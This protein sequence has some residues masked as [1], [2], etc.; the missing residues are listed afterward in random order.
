M[1][2]SRLLQTLRKLSPKDLRALR[3]AARNP[4]WNPRPE[5]AALAGYV[6]DLLLHPRPPVRAFVKTRVWDAVFPGKTYSEKELRYFMSWLLDVV[7]RYLAAAELER[8]PAMEKI[9]LCRALRARGLDELFEK[10]QKEALRLLDNDPQRDARNHYQRYLLRQENIEQHAR[11]R[12]TEGID[13]QPLADDLTAFYAAEILRHAC[14]SRMQETVARRSYQFSLLPAVLDAAEQGVF[15]ESPVVEIFFAAYRTQDGEEK[16]FLALKRLLDDFWQQLSSDDMRGLYLL[17]INFC[18]RKMNAGEAAYIREALDLYRS[19]LERNLLTENGH[20]TGF[21]YKN[22]VRL[23]AHLNEI[24]WAES[25]LETYKPLLHPRE[26]DNAY[27]YNLA[28]LYFQQEKYVNVLPL[29]QTV[30]LDDRLNNLDA[31]RMLLRCYYELGEFQALDSHLEAF[32]TYIRRQ[33]DLGYHKENYLNLIRFTKKLLEATTGDKR[34]IHLLL[35]ELE[36]TAQVAEKK[37]LLSKLAG[38]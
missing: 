35:A 34:K 31:R 32:T 28:F 22:I 13:F 9:L 25:F 36:A 19:A 38:G 37:W 20:L 10:E 24:A 11:T 14:S 2:D 27:R 6:V 15:R 5:V 8:D 29:L 4:L 7:R 33:K 21:T 17:A 16:Y 30:D 3:D 18:I 1:H 23:A 26:R 12:R